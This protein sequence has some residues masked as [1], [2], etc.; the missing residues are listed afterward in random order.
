MNK[1][2]KLPQ[3]KTESR[4]TFKGNANF[5]GDRDTV[6]TATTTNDPTTTLTH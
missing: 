6:T 4:F 3:K 1:L 2:Q 5:T